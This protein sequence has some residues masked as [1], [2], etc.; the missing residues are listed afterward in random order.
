MQTA[1]D[2]ALG[3]IEPDIRV[4][5][6]RARAEQVPFNSN[7]RHVHSERSENDSKVSASIRKMDNYFKQCWQYVIVTMTQEWSVTD[8]QVAR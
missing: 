5:G 8:I 7:S 4:Q 1:I 2:A 6:V 3:T